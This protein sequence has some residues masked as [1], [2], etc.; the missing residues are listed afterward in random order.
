MLSENCKT[1]QE[2]LNRISDEQF[3]GQRALEKE[4]KSTVEYSKEMIRV[5][6]DYANSWP[7]NS[8]ERKYAHEWISQQ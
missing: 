5:K 3:E 4:G 7:E 1:I 8:E 2:V 6:R